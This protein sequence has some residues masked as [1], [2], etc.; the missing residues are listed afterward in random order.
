MSRFR[1]LPLDVPWHASSFRDR[2]AIMIR[3]L[4]AAAAA[5]GLLACADV[6]PPGTSV[7][8]SRPNILLVVADDLGYTDLGAFGGEIPTP[9]LDA[10]ARSGVRLTNFHTSVSCAPTRSML[11][12]G[13][14]NHLAG[15]GSQGSLRTPGQEGHPGYQ[16]RLSK[17]VKSIAMRLKD[18]GYRTYVSGKWH[19][20]TEA[21]CLPGARGFDRSLVLGAGG[22]SHF[23]QLP[24]FPE[25]EKADWYMDDQPIDIP[26]GFYST[27][28]LTNTLMEFIEDDPRQGSPFFAYLAYTAPHWPLHAPDHLLE[29]YRGRYAMGYD[30]LRESRMA[31]AIREKIVP[32]TAVSVS[33]TP[34]LL[35]WR[36]L[37]EQQ[38]AGLPTGRNRPD[39]VN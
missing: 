27:V 24:L 28:D 23:D 20:G 39:A 22:A 36:G 31:G 19:L 8:D 7:A 29:K 13:T 16:N 2:R 5:V 33:D 25:Y 18:V 37:S 38:Q 6:E 17:S 15:M 1:S 11:L 26:A 21:Q 14:D 12:S 4:F 35:P 32:A 3:G 34:G 10:L 9:N 30:E